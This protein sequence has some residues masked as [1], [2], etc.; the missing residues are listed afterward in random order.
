MSAVFALAVSVPLESVAQRIPQDADAEY[1]EAVAT[2]DQR[3]YQQS[4]LAFESF[5]ERYPDHPNAAQALYFEAKSALA[6][7][8][9]NEAVRLFEELQEEY[10]NHPRAEEA[11]LSLG[12][13]FLDQGD[14]S[15]GRQQLERI[16]SRNPQS[17][18][19]ARALYLLGQNQRDRGNLQQALSYYRRASEQPSAPEVASAAL[20]AAGATHVEQ[21]QY[22]KAV[23]SFESLGQRYP[24]SPYAQN[25]GTALA[26]VYYRLGQYERAAQELQSRLP[27]LSGTT[28]HRARFL[29]AESYNQLRRTADAAEQYQQ[30]LDGSAGSA[31][32]AGPYR[33]PALF[34]L[35]WNQWFAGTPS[36]A[37]P[38]FEQVRR[39]HSD[40]LARK[41]TYHEAVARLQMG[42]R[43]QAQSLFQQ[44]LDTWPN[45]TYAATAQYEIGA[46]AYQDENYDAA[47]AAFRSV[48]RNYDQSDK[49]GEAYYWLGN[50]YRAQNAPDRALE[51]YDQAISL[52][53][54]P[55][56][57]R[58]EVQ[59]QTAWSHYENERYE[60]AATG[61]SQLADRASQSQRGSDAL[62]WGADSYV[63]TGRYGQAR[64][65][66]RRYLEQ[67]PGG[68]HAVEAHYVLGWTYFKQQ[69][70][71]QAAQEFQAFLDEY[72]GEDRTVPYRQDARLRLGDSYYAL[73]RYDRAVEVYRGVEGEGTD[74][75]LY[76]R[77]QALNFAGRPEEAVR[78]LR[79]LVDNYPN[80][81]WRQEA[82]YRIGFI[83]FQQQNYAAA[84]DAYRTLI[85][86]YPN[87]RYAAQA[88]YG[89][90]DTYYNAGELRRA[91]SAYR[92]V[93]EQYP[94]SST[95]TEA[96]SSLFFALS[97]AGASD[98]ADA[99]VDSFAQANPD[100]NI[101]SE[102]RFRRA[103]AA[104]QSGDR[105][106]ALRLFRR[107]TRQSSDETLLPRAYYF[108]GVIYADREEYSEAETYLRQLVNNYPDSD[109]HPEAAL[110][111]GDIT[112]EQ[113]QYQAALDVYRT[114]AES[115]RIGAELQAQ[116]RYGQSLA[117]TNLGQMSEAENLLRRIIDNNRGG[118][119]LA[120]ARLGL[121][122]IYEERGEPTQALG[123]YRQVAENAQSEAGA[124]SLYRLGRLLRQQGRPSDA[125]RELNRMPSLFAGYPEW[126]ARS[127]LEQARAHRQLGQTGEA[128]QLYDQVQRE[129]SGTPFAQTARQEQDAL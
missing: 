7:G 18:Q 96:A 2:F 74:Y 52:G 13:Y 6:L 61:F 115:D 38:Y 34:G 79:Q 15:R 71:Q 66:L 86:R 59:F 32:A 1:A 57:L 114:A 123:L 64:Q 118:P 29:L 116:A 121:A 48:V 5:R 37:V 20:Y 31:D 51:A 110:R 14:P 30:L 19:A 75:A 49:R 25:L 117:L 103:E 72:E 87:D 112:L 22:E 105:D 27:D 55:D 111:L 24:G 40:D 104:Y 89:I 12:Q 10:P 76:Q 35:G 4:T 92:T 11:Q 43:Q 98:E 77:G 102:L 9:Q 90:G 62:F 60:Q 21:E 8:R 54:A 119:L 28:R 39:G 113:N 84:R 83:Q 16:V 85:N 46:L 33:R 81:S 124:E 70:Y 58:Y 101:V 126:I 50:T 65:M 17:P 82:L 125:V 120:S 128:N 97:A 93:L 45:S 129:Y 41:A 109:R 80:S 94:N 127:M 47:A 53:A 26:E 100:A 69:S 3:L 78:T 88:Q 99:V 23:S 36:E 107:F 68:R 91:A 73:K 95:A 67:H 108:L 106:E 42:Q 63:Q 122:R 56:S 44:L